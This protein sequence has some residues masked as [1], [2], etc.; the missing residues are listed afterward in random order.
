MRPTSDTRIVAATLDL[1]RSG[2]PRAVTIEAVAAHA[3]VARTTIYRR[4]ADR[5]EMLHAALEVLADPEPMPALST[6]EERLRWVIVT[7]TDIVVSGIGFGGLA[8]LITGSDPAFSDAFRDVLTRHRSA[9]TAAI[10]EGIAEGS[11][12]AD[13]EPETFVDGIVG[14]LVSECARTGGISDDY[15]ERLVTLFLP[16]ARTGQ[17]RPRHPHRSGESFI[18]AVD[19]ESA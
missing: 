12:R 10:E 8:A 18:H 13:L 5:E 14:V 17:E 16:T 1:M 11:F 4:Y 19:G 2:G 3:G 15:E 6:P 9:L 7:A